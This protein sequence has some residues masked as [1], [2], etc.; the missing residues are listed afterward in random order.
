MSLRIGDR[1]PGLHAQ[2]TP[3]AAAWCAALTL[4][5]LLG[6]RLA[7]AVPLEVYGSLPQIEDVSL[8]PDG[9]QIA[10]V[11]TYGDTRIIWTGPLAD[12]KKALPMKVGDEKLRS[13]RWA[14]DSHVLI[15][16]SATVLPAGF[17][18]FRGEVSQLQ[19][20]DV[21][22]RKARIVPKIDQVDTRNALHWLN[23]ISGNPMVRTLGGHTVLFIRG[24]YYTSRTHPALFRLDL[25]T[26]AQEIIREGTDSTAG[27]LVGA[28]GEVIAEEDYLEVKQ[29]WLLLARLNGDPKMSQVASG[30]EGIDLPQLLGFGSEPDTLLIQMPENDKTVWKLLSLR[31]GKLGAP[32]GQDRSFQGAIEADAM[33]RMVGGAY[34]DDYPHYVFFDPQ[35]EE[36]WDAILSAFSGEHVRFVSASSD[37]TKFVVLVEGAAH[38]FAYFI[39]DLSTGHARMLGPVYEGVTHPFEV[40]RIT[41][42]AQDGFMVPAYLT[43]PSG[44]G[45][46]KLPLI[47]LPHGGPAAR[48]DAEFDWWSQAYADQG[49]A[50]LQPNY[51]GS[52]VDRQFLEAGFGQFGRKM[53]TDLSDGVRYLVKEGIVD[54]ARVCIVGGSYG[55]YAALAGV[56][57]DPG[58]YRCAVSIAGLS[59]LKRQLHE[60]GWGIA[61]RFWDRFMGVTGPG[62]PTLAA[63]SPIEHVDAIKVPVLLIHGHDDTVVPFE[64]SQVMFDAM[65]RAH[66]DVE[67]VQLAREDHWLSH[68]ETRLQMLK[69]SVEFLRAHNPPD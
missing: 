59:D 44:R 37:F 56:T 43:L 58:V 18:C 33:H 42:S 35:I 51:R 61:Q 23:A 2:R 34:L 54:P 67:L 53:Q 22:A 16:M 21:A 13:I 66:K 41:Y 65:K 6:A 3:R 55:G 38:G 36:R 52:D 8:S 9:S 46:K 57:L 69:A 20:L 48:D 39:I 1:A 5:G 24:V 27:W 29:Q 28:D 49:Y 7:C 15:T 10:F 47:V 31:D 50:V 60:A 17:C 14:D 26:G 63:I 64:Q 11:R 4:T 30:H 19:V 40:R 45:E 12:P 68:S 62:D 25:T 32:L